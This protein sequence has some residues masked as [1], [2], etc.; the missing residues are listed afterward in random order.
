VAFVK[1]TLIILSFLFFYAGNNI[2]HAQLWRYL[3]DSPEKRKAFDKE[4]KKEAFSVITKKNVVDGD[5]FTYDVM[6]H[7]IKAFDGTTAKIKLWEKSFSNH[8]FHIELPGDTLAIGDFYALERVHHLSSDLLEIVY[9]P[10]GG[11]DDGYNNVLI[12]GVNKGKFCIVAE[13]QSGHEFGDGFYGLRLKLL[14]T[15]INNYKM[16][17]KERDFLQS[18]D[19]RKKSHDK[20]ASFLLKFDKDQHIFYTANRQMDAYTYQ[21]DYITKKNHVKGI[22]PMIELGEYRYCFYNKAWYSIGEDFK[23]GETSMFS[24]CRRSALPKVKR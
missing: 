5:T 3:N 1:R 14:G 19:K 17:I 21:D 15:G 24:Y 20:R 2:A 23:T 9:S 11:S 13:I 8:V 6:T 7:A 4:L 12:L 22:Y 16:G 10:R 18:D